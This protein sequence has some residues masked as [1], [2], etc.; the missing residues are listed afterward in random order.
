MIT[1]DMKIRAAENLA[2]SVKDL[3]FDK[4]IP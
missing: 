1:D 2:N 4:I 3:S